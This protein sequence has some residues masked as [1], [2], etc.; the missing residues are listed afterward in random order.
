MAATKEKK[1]VKTEK[2]ATK[3]DLEV[4][5]YYHWLERGSP[6]DDSLTDW[7]EVENKWRDNILPSR[8]D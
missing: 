8:N 1:N 7:V 4:A 5:A 6:N 3:K 2:K